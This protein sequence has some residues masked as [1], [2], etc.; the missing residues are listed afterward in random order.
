MHAKMALLALKLNEFE[1]LHFRS[2]SHFVSRLSEQQRA[3][4]TSVSF[5]LDDDTVNRV[6]EQQANAWTYAV[7]PFECRGFFDRD[8]SFPLERLPGLTRMVVEVKNMKQEE[9]RF[10]WQRGFVRG[11][12]KQW[13]GRDGL[14]IVFRQWLG[15][16]R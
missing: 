12:I 16:L 7:R 1:I 13:G 11:M 14:A 3:A 8:I 5:V 9:W 2:L 4:I 15:N 10:E 6:L